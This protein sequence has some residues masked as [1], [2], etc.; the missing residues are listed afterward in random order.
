MIAADQEENPVL[1]CIFN[2]SN[3]FR[4][5]VGDSFVVPSPQLIEHTL[6][7]GEDGTET[8]EVRIV[9]IQN[10]SALTYNGKRIP[11]NFCALIRASLSA[12]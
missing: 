7:V 5:L 2:T 4:A 1:L 11:P 8:L 9:S 10:P 12:K 3:E 6:P